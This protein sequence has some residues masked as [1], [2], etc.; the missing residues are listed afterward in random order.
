MSRYIVRIV[1]EDKNG[2]FVNITPSAKMQ[3]IAE[4]IQ[5]SITGIY[6][7]VT[8]LK[9]GFNCIDIHTEISDS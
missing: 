6:R 8:K 5:S 1:E 4:L 3:D 7:G 2:Y 9:V